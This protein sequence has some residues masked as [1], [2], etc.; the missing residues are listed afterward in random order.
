M[1][2][3]NSLDVVWT[4]RDQSNALVDLTGGSI[5]WNLY[6][7]DGGASLLAKSTGAGIVLTDPTNGVCTMTLDGADTTNMK[8]PYRYEGVFTDAGSNVYTFDESTM[9]IK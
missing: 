4:I 5:A 9:V 1:T 8:G 2:A 7:I 6:P 3:G